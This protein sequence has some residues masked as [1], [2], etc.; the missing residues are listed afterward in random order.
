MYEGVCIAAGS[1][2]LSVAL[3]IIFLL[4]LSCISVFF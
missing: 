2:F 4:F 1:Q 3:I